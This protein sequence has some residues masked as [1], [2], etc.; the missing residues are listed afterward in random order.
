MTNPAEVPPPRSRAPS[1]TLL[2]GLIVALAVGVGVDQLLAGRPPAGLDAIREK[3]GGDTSRPGRGEDAY[4]LPAANRTTRDT[5]RFFEGQRLFNLN[6][7]KAPSRIGALDGR[8]PTFNRPRC[9]GCHERDGRGRPPDPKDPEAAMNSI[10]VRLSVPGKGPHGGPNPH[11]AYGLQLQ[12]RSIAGVP[13]E[14]RAFIRWETVK[15]A[16]G[17]GTPYTLRRPMLQFERLAFGP[18]GP[19]IRTSLRVAPQLVGMGLLDAVPAAAIRRMADPKDRNGDGI[20]GRVNRVWNPATGRMEIGRFGWKSGS[21]TLRQQ[22]ADAFRNDMGL[23]NRLFPTENCPPPQTACRAAPTGGSPEVSDR[24]LADVVFYISMLAVPHRRRVE[25]AD[26]R[27]GQELFGR[28]GCAGCHRPT[29]R[30]GKHPSIPGLSNQVIHPFTDLLLHDM[31]PGLADRRPE[32]RASGREWRTA[33]LWGI[34]LVPEVNGHRLYLHDGRAR[35][36]AEAILWHGG[37]AEA[38]K[39]R[40]RML[41]KAARDALLAF[42]KSL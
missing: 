15:G 27:R 23:T 21:A 33:P 3:L 12:E 16:Y 18:L 36:L 35:G 5:P 34:G 31:G 9:S 10:L 39:E 1:R 4:A 17:D 26:V 19:D 2:A 24:I 41:S 13:G 32:Y 14:G 6:W 29:L 28:I 11:P 8:G 37:E 42:L 40:F 20:S 38:A 7:V 22:I 25:A 30:T